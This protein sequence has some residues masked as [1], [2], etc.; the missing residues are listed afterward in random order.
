M[1]Q[2]NLYPFKIADKRVFDIP[3]TNIESCYLC[4]KFLL[5]INLIVGFEY[6]YKNELLMS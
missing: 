6:Q 2:G 4:G 5:A 1:K 3:S